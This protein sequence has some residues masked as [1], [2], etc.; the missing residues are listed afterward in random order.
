M[1]KNISNQQAKH[2][3]K[4][5]ARIVDIRD[6]KDFGVSH[7]PGALNISINDLDKISFNKDTPII[8]VC[9]GGIRSIAAVER[10]A[11]LGYTRVYNLKNGYDNYK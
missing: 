8:V 1:T 4:M 5:G 7:I 11:E 3:I 10:L 6:A 9:Y 2:L